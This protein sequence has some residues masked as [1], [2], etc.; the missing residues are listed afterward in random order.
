MKQVLY[1]LIFLVNAGFSQENL[2][3]L[4]I[5]PFFS[6]SNQSP[7]FLKP[8]NHFLNMKSAGISCNFPILKLGARLNLETG[9]ILTEK[10]TRNKLVF[11]V[12]GPNKYGFIYRYTESFLFL[13]CPLRFVANGFR[14][15][16]YG[17]PVASVLLQHTQQNYMFYNVSNVVFQQSWN[18]GHYPMIYRRLDFG[19][20]AGV[21]Y[22]LLENMSF[23]FNYQYGFYILRKH[24]DI[25]T[26]E[27]QH[28]QTFRIG[29]QFFP[30][31]AFV[32]IKRQ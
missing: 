24:P 7:G 9:L 13:E 27:I 30:W 18:A 11:T 26:R 28:Q 32:P 29:L 19:M 21:R 1:V 15:S 23:D 2:Q 31:K 12:Y 17:G 22:Q 16:G 14:I 3:K 8:T 5:T 6:N 4:S 25:M 10:G 20:N